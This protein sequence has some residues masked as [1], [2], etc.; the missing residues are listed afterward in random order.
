MFLY[1]KFRIAWKIAV[2]YIEQYWSS[3]SIRNIDV[4]LRFLR[5]HVGGSNLGKS[6]DKQYSVQNILFG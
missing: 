4:F 6:I 1:S 5:I 3:T 2:L